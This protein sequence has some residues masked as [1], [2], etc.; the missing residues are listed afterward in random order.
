[1][2]IRCRNCKRC[3]CTKTLSG[4]KYYCVKEQAQVK[5]LGKCTRFFIPRTKEENP[6]ELPNYQKENNNGNKTEND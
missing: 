6:Y 1:M 2:K 3:V 4:K 5:G